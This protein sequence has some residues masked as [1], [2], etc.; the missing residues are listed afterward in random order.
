MPPKRSVKLLQY[1]F[2]RFVDTLP[3]VRSKLRTHFAEPTV[4]V[5]MYTVQLTN[6][7]IRS[8]P[9]TLISESMVSFADSPFKFPLLPPSR[10][11]DALVLAFGIVKLLH[12]VRPNQRL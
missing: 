1:S 5:N 11:L 10:F 4:N 9:D 7:K 6:D 12:S 8:Y 3:I 2:W